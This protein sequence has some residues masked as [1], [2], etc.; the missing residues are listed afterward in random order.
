MTEG[1]TLQTEDEYQTL[2]RWFGIEKVALISERPG[3]VLVLIHSNKFRA[4]WNRK[5][6][7]KVIDKYKPVTH[8]VKVAMAI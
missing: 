6:I 5:K 8:L 4:W 2:F 3:M 1:V 7:Y